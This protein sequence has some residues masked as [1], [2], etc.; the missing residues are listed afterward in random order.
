MQTTSALDVDALIGLP[1]QPH[2][3]LAHPRHEH[4][5]PLVFATAAAKALHRNTVTFPIEGFWSIAPAFSKRSVQF[6]CA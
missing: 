2:A 3:G 5:S 1:S 4:F 6:S